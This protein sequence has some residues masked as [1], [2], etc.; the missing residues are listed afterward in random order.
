M[1][2]AGIH[3]KPLYPQARIPNVAPFEW[4]PAL[5]GGFVAPGPPAQAC[6]TSSGAKPLDSAADRL[7]SAGPKPAD[8]DVPE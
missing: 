8:N 3:S 7:A 4:I 2:L 5:V 1:Q 6:L